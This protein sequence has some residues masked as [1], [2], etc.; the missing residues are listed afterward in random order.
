MRPIA[1]A[2][3][4]AAD[5]ALIG[6]RGPLDGC[7]ALLDQCSLFRRLGMGERDAL[8]ARARV[9]SYA[10]HQTIFSMG[11]PGDSMVAVLSGTIRI[12]VPSSDGKEVVLAL[13]G[14][15]EICGEIA[16]LDGKERTADARAATDCSVVVLER[17]DVLAFFARYPEAWAKLIE[18]L[19]ER[20]RTA[21]QQMAAFALSPVP[22]RLAKALLR[23]AAT[24]GHARAGGFSAVPRV[25]LTQ[26]ELGNVIGATRESVNKYLRAWQRK[27]YV[28]ISDCL[29]IITNR[30]ALENLAE[31]VT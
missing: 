2:D 26:R 18:V 25:H 1:P 11:S 31:P 15:G 29:I 28:R 3:C 8:F 16:L 21:D 27:G 4:G 22:V 19:C 13:L 23:L 5:E 12:S 7:R 17:R 6:V 9:Q 14:C 10:V 20:L 30:A 24:N